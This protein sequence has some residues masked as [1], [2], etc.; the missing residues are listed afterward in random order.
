M[1]ENVND[2]DE[3]FAE[4][5]SLAEIG[6][7]STIF[8]ADVSE[9]MYETRSDGKTYLH[10]AFAR[11]TAHLNYF[12]LNSK[13]NE[14]VTVILLNASPEKAQNGI[15]VAYN[16]DN[17]CVELNQTIYCLSEAEDIKKEVSE[18]YGKGSSH[19]DICELIFCCR[20]IFSE[21]SNT[22]QKR[23]IFYS[24]N[25]DPYDDPYT[26]SKHLELVAK[27][28]AKL[29]ADIH[30]AANLIDFPLGTTPNE[31]WNTI[32]PSYKYR[33]HPI[34]PTTEF[35]ESSL[36]SAA[37]VPFHLGGAV[38]MA[39]SCYYVCHERQK[40][41]S[42]WLDAET[43]ECVERTGFL[44]EAGPSEADS[45]AVNLSTQMAAEPKPV[46]MSNAFQMDWLV[47]VAGVDIQLTRR[48][49]DLLGRIETPG[50]RLLGFKP[51]NEFKDSWRMGESCY[52]YPLDKVVTG[53]Q[54][55]YRSL[56]LSCLK[57]N[58]YAL[59]RCTF[60]SNTTSKLYALIPQKAPPKDTEDIKPVDIHRYEGFHAVRLPLKQNKRDLE[61]E[62]EKE[63]R[64]LVAPSTKPSKTIS[65][66]VD[67]LTQEYTPEMFF[68]PQVQSYNKM[69]ESLALKYSFDKCK[70]MAEGVDQHKAWFD[71]KDVEPVENELDRMKSILSGDPANE[72]LVR[73]RRQGTQYGQPDSKQTRK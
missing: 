3:H 39:V 16:T 20:R 56:Y 25:Y 65:G 54:N 55:L 34:E 17:V 15:Y 41:E 52:L 7:K 6:R 5:A 69:I 62:M 22:S 30:F 33:I 29:D 18:F 23:V 71:V 53:S 35:I 70:E 37:V 36:R 59:A 27:R 9:K 47:S 45:E 68:N 28:M 19:A 12:A 60:R 61:C 4:E 40:P 63:T 64:Q 31:F 57:K 38:E 13:L 44:A 42:T 43:N 73:K 48:E 2:N 51:L 67:K 11:L 24:Y 32:D 66:F 14:Y 1:D 72:K 50:I 46:D 8:V 58:V 26:K 49:R 21:G 10:E